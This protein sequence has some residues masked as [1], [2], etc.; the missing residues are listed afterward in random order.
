M[1]IGNGSVWFFLA[2]V[3]LFSAAVGG[4]KKTGGGDAEPTVVGIPGGDLN[5][6]GTFN[7]SAMQ[8]IEAQASKPNLQ[9]AIF[10]GRLTDAGLMQLAKFPNLRKVEAIGSVVTA[11]GIA[12][13]KATI[14]ELEVTE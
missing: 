12:K 11:A 5:A 14:P 8:K 9:I 4:C 3:C 10:R 13:L 7:D 1:A 2:L 6:D